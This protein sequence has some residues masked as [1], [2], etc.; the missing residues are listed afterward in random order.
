[1]RM[2][3]LTTCVVL[4]IATPCV[5]AQRTDDSARTAEGQEIGRVQPKVTVSQLLR[6]PID[7]VD[8]DERSFE[9]VLDW[10]R[11]QGPGVNVIAAWGPL[12]V[13]AIERESFVESLYLTNTT[14]GEVLDE[15]IAQL[16]EDG[17]VT[18]RGVGSTLRI[19]TKADFNR[20]LYVKVYDATDILQ[21]IPDFGNQ[22]PR[23]DIQQASQ[24]ASQGGGGGGGQSIFS[25]SSTGGNEEGGEQ[26]ERELE[27]RLEEL[28]ELVLAIVEPTHWEENGGQGA[29][30]IFNRNLVVRA[31]IEVHEE[32]AGRFRFD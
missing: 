7:E 26:A 25:G 1:M 28:R 15:V 4:A 3:N 31:S 11:E 27:E 22:A 20:K 17:E 19:S 12:G 16:S 29:I 10:V 14:V 5:L 32:I 21:R 13:E 23:I 6:T 2:R 30:R 24:Q 8:W 9:Y 18:Y